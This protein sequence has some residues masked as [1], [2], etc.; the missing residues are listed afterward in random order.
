MSFAC[1]I[2]RQ[3]NF[4]NAIALVITVRE[5][6]SGGSFIISMFG[7]THLSTGEILADPIGFGIL[8][9]KADSPYNRTYENERQG[10]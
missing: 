3:P 6:F 5:F 10:N 9:V 8:T 1:W 4:R 7:A 2:S